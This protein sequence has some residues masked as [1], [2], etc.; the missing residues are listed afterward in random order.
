MEQKKLSEYSMQYFY[1]TRLAGFFLRA[2]EW[3][4]LN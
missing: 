2:E 4:V 3:M 1:E